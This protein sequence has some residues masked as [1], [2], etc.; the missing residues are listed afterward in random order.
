MFGRQKQPR[1]TKA[2]IKAELEQKAEVTEGRRFAREVIYPIVKKHSISLKDASNMLEIG[3]VVLQ[4]MQSRL[5]KDKTVKDLGVLEELE[6]DEK[7]TDKEK[8]MDLFIV[9]NDLPVDK[10][11]M[12]LDEFQAAIDTYIK[13]EALNKPFEATE[14]D[15]IAK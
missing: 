11:R 13:R 15:L 3:K 6:A 1:K 10:A 5:W 9:L 7:F 2:Q 14:D 4:M 8:F 12:H